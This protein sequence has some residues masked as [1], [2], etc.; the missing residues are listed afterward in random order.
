MNTTT[1]LA[2]LR[3]LQNFMERTEHLG[4]DQEDRE[5]LRDT[6]SAI[7]RLEQ[8]ERAAVQL[9]ERMRA[10]FKSCLKYGLPFAFSAM[11]L[12]EGARR[13]AEQRNRELA[14]RNGGAQ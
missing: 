14:A 6:E 5:L 4:L 13:Y 11:F 3:R 8:A 1:I 12:D 9:R 7:F 10:S 2:L